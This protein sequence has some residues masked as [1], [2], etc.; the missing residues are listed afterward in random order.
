M[1]L[2]VNGAMVASSLGQSGPV[3]DAATQQCKQL[4]LG[5]SLMQEATYRGAM[6]ELIIWPESR[7]H[8]NIKNSMFNN[9]AVN[10]G[11]LSNIIHE[12]FDFISEWEDIGDKAPIL[13]NSDIPTEMHDLSLHV[14]PCGV[15]ICD[16]PTVMKSYMERPTLRRSKSLRYRVVSI[17]NDDGSMPTVTQEQIVRQHQEINDAFAPHNISWELSE[18]VVRNSSLRRRVVL[19]SCHASDIGNDRCNEECREQ[20]TGNDG[21]DC[22]EVDTV[23]ENS[24]LGDGQCDEEC[25]KAYH[26]WDDGDCCDPYVTNINETCFD[27]DSPFR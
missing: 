1:K 25:N 19:H 9:K 14:P 3:F 5:G 23:C 15:T 12:D 8:E 27:P 17:A 10:S 22:D 20:T 13:V 7:G 2:Y 16:N 18:I 24:K 4:V 21:G 26:E 11:H 6:D